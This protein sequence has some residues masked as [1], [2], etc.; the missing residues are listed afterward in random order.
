[1]TR[2]FF[3]VFAACVATPAAAQ[4]LA[5]RADAPAAA[6]HPVATTIATAVRTP[7][8]PQIDGVGNDDTWRQAPAVD[9]F[10]QFDPKEDVDPTF[11]TEARFA[12]DDRNLYVLVRAFDPNPDSI[13]ALLSRRDERTQS[14]YI[15]VIVDSYHDKRTGYQFM[16]NPAGVKRDI[17]LYN[18]T[19]EDVSW[20]AVWDV[21]TSIDSLGWLA[22]FRIPLSQLRYPKRESHTFGVAVHREVGRSNERSS[23]PVWRRSQAGLA[24]QLGEVHGIVGISSPRRLEVMP[25]SVQSNASVSR[26]NDFA[27]TQRGTMG[28]DIKYGLSSNLTLDAA[29]N[30]DF[31]QVEADPSVLNLS[32]FEQFFGEQRPFFLEGTGILRFDQDCND[33][34]C[35]GLFYSRRIGRAP[36]LGFLSPS[37]GAVPTSSTILGAAKV[38]GRL[39]NG[40]SIGILNAV[41]DREMVGDDVEVE[42][43][44]NYFVARLNQ[45]LRGGRSGVGAVLTAVNRQLDPTAEPY[46]RSAG[47]TAGIDARHRFGPG[48]NLSLSGSAVGSV[49]RGSAEAIAATQRSSVHYYQRPGDDIEYDPT[50]TDLSGYALNVGLNKNGGG[51]T[52]FYT[53]GWYKS[54]GLEINDVGFMTNVNNMGWSNWFALVFQEPKAFYR[55]LQ[56]NF[57]Q[58]NSFMVDGTNT[59][60]GGNVNTNIT[61]KNMWFMYAGIGG[62][63][64]SV[65]GACLR[66]GPY[67]NEDANLN[68]WFG[69]SG[70]SRKNIVPGLSTWYN[71][72][73]GGA[74]FNYGLNPYINLRVASRLSGQVGLTYQKNIDDRQWIRNFGVAGHDTTHYTVGHLAQQTLNLNTRIN[75]TA[76][77][78]LSVQF[79]ASP[80]VS[81]G[82]YSDWRE[83][84][85]PRH[86]QYAE[87]YRPF[88]AGGDPGDNDFNFKQFRSNLVMRWEYRPGST[89]FLVWGQGREQ[90]DR[91]LGNFGGFRDYQNLFSSHPANTFLIKASYWFSL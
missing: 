26:A 27:R 84:T 89:L 86:A 24:S 73:D 12:Y 23:W 13:M 35:T 6:T 91:D 17:Y 72:R 88:S 63:R 44:T 77:P 36:Q 20:D 2:S 16:V 9:G 66:G 1:M 25:Y 32:A 38:T 83:V 79:Y 68:T 37:A 47:Y 33:G 42:P 29:I 43:M 18:D 80:F 49:V 81:V 11:R 46:L 62:E 74:S 19:N 34:Q 4:Q 65:C 5:R 78:T 58:W 64:A 30:P 59:G 40:L 61:F 39:G 48:G 71:R 22:E 67:L 76:S 82:E 55:R 54:P 57:N 60:V 31:G 56:V 69:F 50:R 51:I 90:A 28:A 52:R 15:R 10:R 14:D 21:K 75:F 70:D 8:S 87:R 85:A 3:L 7:S 53:G 41:T 45:D